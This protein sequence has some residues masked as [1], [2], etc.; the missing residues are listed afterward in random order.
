MYNVNSF[1]TV[2]RA[3]ADVLSTYWDGSLPVPV[4]EIARTMGARVVRRVGQDFPYSGY[5]RDSRDT[6]DGNPT[7]EFNGADSYTRQRF[8]I[9]HELAHFAL[10]HGTSPRDYPNSFNAGTNDPK[11]RAANQFAAEI[12]MP[13]QTV[14]NVIMRGYASSVDELASMFG[15]STLAMG[16]RLHNIGMLV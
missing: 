14:R 12:L 8:T 4:D 2:Q 6:V 9:A 13:E 16:Y 1:S 5:F 7:I 3:A 11:E 10:R 15:V